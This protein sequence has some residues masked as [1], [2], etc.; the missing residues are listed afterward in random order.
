MLKIRDVLVRYGVTKPTIYRWMK[1]GL[2]PA[3]VKIGGG[4]V[5]WLEADLEAF[6]QTVR[7]SQGQ[8]KAQ[9]CSEVYIDFN[10]LF[11]ENEKSMLDNVMM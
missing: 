10:Q 2:F 1:E 8:C 7:E 11:K 4:T 6:D 9:N 3:P 5:R